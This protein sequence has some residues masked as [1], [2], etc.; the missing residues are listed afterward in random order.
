LSEQIRRGRPV[1]DPPVLNLSEGAFARGVR[2]TPKAPSMSGQA[3]GSKVREYLIERYR[4]API[5]L[6]LRLFDGGVEACTIVII[7]F[8]PIIYNEQPKLGIVRQVD[9]VFDNDASAADPRAQCQ[10]HR[11]TVPRGRLGGS[12]GAVSADGHRAA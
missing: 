6:C 4:L 3:P 1:R 11:D 5:D 9:G 2:A 7:Q 8:I 12:V 10:G